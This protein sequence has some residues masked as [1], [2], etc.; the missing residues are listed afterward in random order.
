MADS[1]AIVT[2][3]PK[4]LRRKRHLLLLQQKGRCCYCRRPFGK[5]PLRVTLEHK[6]P[7]RDGGGNN[8]ENL[9][10]ACLHCNQHRG[11]QINA[12]RQRKAK[13]QDGQP[14]AE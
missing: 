1:V 7:R 11:R 8:I 14:S 10:A 13:K 4:V 12:S 5:G 6:K 2:M 3:K 9:A